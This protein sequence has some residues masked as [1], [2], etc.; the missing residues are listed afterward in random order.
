M[1]GQD[2]ERLAEVLAKCPALV[3]LDLRSNS[4]FGAAGTETLAGVLGQCRELVNFNLSTN[5]IDYSGAE[6]LGVLAQCTALAHLNL[7]GVTL[8][9]TQ[10]ALQECWRSAQGWLT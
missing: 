10:G 7:S 3:H 2:S 5:F 6:R 9:Q 4:Y 1:K 8:E